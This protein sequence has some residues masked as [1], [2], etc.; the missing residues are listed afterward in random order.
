MSLLTGGYARQTVQ[1]RPPTV[2]GDAERGRVGQARSSRL[3]LVE[4]A[5]ELPAMSPPLHIVSEQRELPRRV[6][7][8]TR[9]AYQEVRPLP[10]HQWTHS[11]AITER[12]RSDVFA[13]QSSSS[14]HAA[15]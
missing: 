11:S 15:V 9:K 3:L 12:C 14:A 6:S 10:V 7:G 1:G 2:E 8:P 5:V 13:E 4:H